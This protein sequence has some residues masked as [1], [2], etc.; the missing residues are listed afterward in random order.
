MGL[1]L[2]FEVI[3]YP[4]CQCTGAAGSDNQGQDQGCKGPYCISV[5]EV[6]KAN[7]HKSQ[8]QTL[9]EWI[10]DARAGKIVPSHKFQVL[11]E[12]E[13]CRMACYSSHTYGFLDKGR[14][15][16][17]FPFACHAHAGV[18]GAKREEI[19]DHWRWTP[20][21]GWSGRKEIY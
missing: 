20:M 10:A 5:L 6:L 14:P 19:I 18:V 12:D 17:S 7:H 9:D 2:D 21:N 13:T 4:P 1:P 15:N 3:G 11:G 8:S 16:I